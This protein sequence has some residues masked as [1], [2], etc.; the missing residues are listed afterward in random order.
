MNYSTSVSS[1]IGGTV[2]DGAVW[3]EI[4]S[5]DAKYNLYRI[6]NNSQ[7]SKKPKKILTDFL[8]F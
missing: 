3:Q 2:V 6:N 1:S 8:S 4:L 7:L 5:T